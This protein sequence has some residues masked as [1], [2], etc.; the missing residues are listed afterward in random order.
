MVWALLR[1]VARREQEAKAI[2]G[3]SRKEV[4]KKLTQ[5]LAK[6]DDGVVFDDEGQSLG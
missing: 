2:Y 6:R 3:K 1:R 5:V 4:T